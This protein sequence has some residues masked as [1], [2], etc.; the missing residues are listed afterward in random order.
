MKVDVSTSVT[1]PLQM[2][3]SRQVKAGSHSLL[4]ELSSLPKSALSLRARG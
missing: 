4:I 1:N 3:V 2:S